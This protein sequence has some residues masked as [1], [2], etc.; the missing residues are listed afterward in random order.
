MAMDFKDDNTKILYVAHL[1]DQALT[2]PDI[3]AQYYQHQS[4]K[5]LGNSN[6]VPRGSSE[7]NHS[8]GKT[9]HR[10]NN[11]SRKPLFNNNNNNNSNNDDGIPPSTMDGNNFGGKK[12][13]K[14][15]II[16]II[17][18]VKAKANL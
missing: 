12:F 3:L 9:K 17:I 5:P 13:K 8:N 18:K 1:I 16:Y 11:Q 6:S 10:S 4:G 7:E 15:K 2:R 14:M